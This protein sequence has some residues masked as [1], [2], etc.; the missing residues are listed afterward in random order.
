[1]GIRPPLATV[2]LA[3]RGRIH[4]ACFAVRV[5]PFWAG[6]G[7]CSRW[8]GAGNAAGDGFLGGSWGCSDRAYL[9]HWGRILGTWGCNVV[10]GVFGEV[11]VGSGGDAEASEAPRTSC[12]VN[13]LENDETRWSCG[14]QA[15]ASV[16]GPGTWGFASSFAWGF[17][18]G[19]A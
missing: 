13:Q 1:M 19:F 9:R 5:L 4:L 11:C 18:W 12:V 16:D 6:S 2:A 7:S 3:G 10:Q 17:A 15:H 8:L 14:V